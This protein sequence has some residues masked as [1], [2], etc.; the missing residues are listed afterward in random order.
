[1]ALIQTALLDSLTPG[2]I[3]FSITYHKMMALNQTTFLGS[4]TPGNI[5]FSITHHKMMALNQTALLDSLTPGNILFSITH[6]KMMALNQTALLGSLTPREYIVQYYTPQD[7]G[8]EPDYFTLCG[9]TPG[10]ILFSITH[11]KMMA[12]IKTTLLERESKVVWINKTF[13][14]FL[15]FSPMDIMQTTKV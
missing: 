4:L 15:R 9:L 12:L 14:S 8:P 6:H 11:H 13:P 5:L 1:M 2:N 10:N 7:D 3:L